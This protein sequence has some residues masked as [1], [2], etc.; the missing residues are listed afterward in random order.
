MDINHQSISAFPTKEVWENVI[1]S[2]Y[3]SNPKEYRKT[4]KIRPACGIC[5]TNKAIWENSII[6]EYR[7]HECVP[8]GCSCRLRK[9][10]KNVL[11]SIENYTY[12]LGDDG[13]ELPCEDWHKF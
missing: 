12:M 11:F 1:S 10:K 2:Y 8:R 9:I 3:K 4:F 6:D 13:E 7:C 5:E